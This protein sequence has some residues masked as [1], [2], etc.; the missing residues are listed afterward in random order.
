MQIEYDTNEVFDVYDP[1]DTLYDHLDTI[2]TVQTGAPLIHALRDLIEFLHTIPTFLSTNPGFR[3]AVA[4]A[5]QAWIAADQIQ[6]N[7]GIVAGDLLSFIES[8]QN[9]NDYV[10]S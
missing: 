9:R 6:T 2:D 10:S 4:Q 3:S 5:C 1:I 7:I 8:L